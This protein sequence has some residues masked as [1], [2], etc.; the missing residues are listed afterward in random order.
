MYNSSSPATLSTYLYQEEKEEEEEG[1]G[2][3]M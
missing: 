3:P 1:E 2:R